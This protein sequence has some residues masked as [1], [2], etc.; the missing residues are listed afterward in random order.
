MSS[1]FRRVISGFLRLRGCVF[2]CLSLLP[3]T[4]GAQQISRL[5]LPDSPGYVL[6]QASAQQA[7]VAAGTGNISGTVLDIN[8][9]L[10]LGAKVTLVELGTVDAPPRQ[11]TVLDS[12]AEGNF[13]FPDLSGGRY[14]ITITSPGLETFISPEINLKPGEHRELPRIALP[15]TAN[16]SVQVTVTQA[17]IAQEEVQ[18]LEKQRI[19]GVIPNFY[20]SYLWDAAP[21]PTRQ[22]FTL[23]LH[24]ILD[25]AIFAVTAIAAGAEQATDTFPEYGQGFKGYASRYGADYG[26][27]FN[28]R[29]F[30]SAIYPTI[31]HQDPRYFYRGTGSKR[32]RFLY[33]ISRA[34][35][36][37][38]DNGK[39]QPNYSRILGSL[40]AGAISNTYHEGRDRG[41]TLVLR[42][43]IIAIA[44]HAADNLLRE[45]FFKAISTDVPQNQRGKPVVSKP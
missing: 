28:N 18:M 21:L 8:E 35:I 7:A 12:D 16:I 27:E 4:M 25:P 39:D 10:V 36:T 26:D 9:G 40:T 14:Q 42:N 17:Q 22:K 31:F 19:L 24:S 11:R 3:L 5:S 15:V 13:L 6:A 20:T 23:A 2:F 38:G 41:S 45:F 33:A 29:M 30:S 34:V 43:G 37:R 44:G 32:Q 1:D